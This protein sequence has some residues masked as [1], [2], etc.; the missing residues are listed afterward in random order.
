MKQL[1]KLKV[2]FLDSY[3]KRIVREKRMTIENFVK[4]LNLGQLSEWIEK[5]HFYIRN[6]ELRQGRISMYRDFMKMHVSAFDISKHAGAI[7]YISGVLFYLGAKIEEIYEA[8]CSFYEEI[9]Y[10]Q[11]T[12]TKYS[13]GRVEL[14]WVRRTDVKCR[15]Y[16]YLKNNTLAKVKEILDG[17]A[18]DRQQFKMKRTT[19]KENILNAFLQLS[20][21]SESRPTEN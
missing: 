5:T 18:E 2:A 15:E 4:T 13:D 6:E 19:D 12:I 16:F 20:G 10:K 11:W 8:S 9:S 21:M 17:P 14:F 1:D 7:D 3:Y